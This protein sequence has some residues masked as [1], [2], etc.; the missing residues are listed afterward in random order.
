MKIM[1][2]EQ[3]TKSD[4]GM[5]PCI[6]F[7]APTGETVKVAVCQVLEGPIVPLGAPYEGGS[8]LKSEAVGVEGCAAVTVSFRG[9]P[10]CLL[11]NA[12][13]LTGFDRE[14]VAKVVYIRSNSKENWVELGTVSGQVE[15]NTY[16]D[17]H[18]PDVQWAKQDLAWC[19]VSAKSNIVRPNEIKEI[20]K[21]TDTLRAPQ[22]GE[23]VGIYGGKSRLIYWDDPDDTI[24]VCVADGK[25]I[26]K[27]E[28][29]CGQEL[30]YAF[31]KEVY[32]IDEELYLFPGDS[33]SAVVG[34]RDNALIG[35]VFSV[36]QKSKATYFCRVVD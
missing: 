35:L 32:R 13:V 6:K 22:S 18:P 23:K 2:W 26:V 29:E 11:S 15:V 20:G 8:H 4:A 10:Y 9:I 28:F 5:Q 12:H 14:N 33:G 7:N 19:E 36:G 17:L 3:A 1:P 30:R 27:L 31:F 34:C 16:P 25:A 21:V 24:Q